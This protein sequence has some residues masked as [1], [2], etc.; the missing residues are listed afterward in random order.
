MLENYND[1]VVGRTTNYIPAKLEDTLYLTQI[2][3]IREKHAGY[4]ARLAYL[5]VAA[6]H[7]SLVLGGCVS[8]AGGSRPPGCRC[9]W[10]G[11]RVFYS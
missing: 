2:N 11:L 10:A 4:G 3:G 9:K 5:A 1:N 8:P 6:A 7:L